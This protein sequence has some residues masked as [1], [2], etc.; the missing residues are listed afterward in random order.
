MTTISP[1]TVSIE[2]NYVGSMLGNEGFTF[3]AALEAALGEDVARTLA[4]DGAMPVT[5]P[6]REAAEELIA[7]LQAINVTHG[8]AVHIAISSGWRV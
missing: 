4:Q 6:T 7:A 3:T 1:V 5:V 2:M 8:H